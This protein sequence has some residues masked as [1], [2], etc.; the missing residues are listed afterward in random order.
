MTTTWFESVHFPEG[1]LQSMG[2][3]VKKKKIIIMERG[4]VVVITVIICKNVFNIIQ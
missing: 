3:W 4:K 1:K 2:G